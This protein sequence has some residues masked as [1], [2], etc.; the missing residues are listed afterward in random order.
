MNVPNFYTSK[1]GSMGLSPAEHKD[2]LK[3]NLESY[4][5]EIGLWEAGLDSHVCDYHALLHAHRD[6]YGVLLNALDAQE[7][8]IANNAKNALD[9]LSHFITTLMHQGHGSPIS[10]KRLWSRYRVGAMM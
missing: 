4:R 8:G 3:K 7:R 5:R 9:S 2:W 1:H 10:C 6:L